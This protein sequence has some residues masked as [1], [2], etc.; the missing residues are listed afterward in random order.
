MRLTVA[1][2]KIEGKWEAALVAENKFQRALLGEKLEDVVLRGLLA[3][4]ET[5]HPDGTIV[6]IDV[7]AEP[8]GANGP[9]PSAQ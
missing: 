7:L 6:T 5:P 2:R 4:L 1:A 8:E 3:V 9:R